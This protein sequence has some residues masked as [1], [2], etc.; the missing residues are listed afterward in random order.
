MNP[1]MR[2]PIRAYRWRRVRRSLIQLRDA[3][4]HAADALAILQRATA[5][6]VAEVDD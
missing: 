6:L 5:D 2:H 4:L 3:G 1:V